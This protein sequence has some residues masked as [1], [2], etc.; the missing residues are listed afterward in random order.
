MWPSRGVQSMCRCR[1]RKGRSICHPNHQTANKTPSILSWQVAARNTERRRQ[2]NR[3]W[4][5]TRWIDW[6]WRRQQA[7]TKFQLLRRNHRNVHV[8]SRPMYN[9]C[10]LYLLL[11][12]RCSEGFLESTTQQLSRVQLTSPFS[13]KDSI[14]TSL[15]LFGADNVNCHTLATASKATKNKETFTN[16]QRCS[17]RSRSDYVKRQ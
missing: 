14:N 5:W 17:Q 16:A 10:N 4:S 15:S 11:S 1:N 2:R 3:S 6:H 8:F 12:R 7:T 9:C 13:N